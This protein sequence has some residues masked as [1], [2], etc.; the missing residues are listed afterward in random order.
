MENRYDIFGCYFGVSFEPLALAWRRSVEQNC[1][2]ATV[3]AQQIPGASAIKGIRQTGPDNLA[4]VARWRERIHDAEKPLLLMDVD[5]FARGD[6]EPIFN[7][8]GTADVAYCWRPGRR[9]V[10]GGVVAV[11]PTKEA[12]QF[13]DTWLCRMATILSRPQTARERMFRDGGL[14]Q[15][16]L[17]ELSSMPTV[18][19]LDPHEWNA[20]DE[21]WADVDDETRII[22]AKGELREHV[23]SANTGGEYGDLVREW[24]TYLPIETAPSPGASQNSGGSSGLAAAGVQ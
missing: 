12:R 11:K 24:R 21:C 4:K 22:H 20:C 2:D 6:L 10:I 7:A 17:N 15:T 3:E 9:P 1:P 18:R 19:L 13:A 5:T 23:L 16:V 8:M 14:S